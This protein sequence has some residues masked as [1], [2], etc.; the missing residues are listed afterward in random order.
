MPVDKIRT[1]AENCEKIY[2]IEELDPFIEEHVRAMGIP[3]IG[4]EAFTM[5][6]EYSAAM[7]RNAVFPEEASDEVFPAPN[8]PMR[9]PVLCPGC[10][11]RGTFYVLKKLGLTVSGDI[12]CYTLGATVPLSSVDTTICMGASVSAAHGMAKVRGAEFNKKLV[13][14]TI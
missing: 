6:Y 14:I 1:F 7:I 3:C 13:S 9:P 10:P 4:K 8:A 11:H 5:L 2:V 12:G